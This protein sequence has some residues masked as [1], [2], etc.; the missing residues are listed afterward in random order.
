MKK[1]LVIT[2]NIPNAI[3]RTGT[4]KRLGSFLHALGRL[5]QLDF[6]F[7]TNPRIEFDPVETEHWIKEIWGVNA[8]AI[9]GCN[10]EPGN[11]VQR[12][13]FNEYI[14]PIYSFKHIDK[15]SGLTRRRQTQFL[16]ELLK[17]SQPDLIFAHRLR[18][19]YPVL[20]ADGALPPVIF[21]LDDIEH[22]VLFRSIKIPPVWISKW[23]W[24]LHIPALMLFERKAVKLA[25]RTFVCSKEDES[26]LSKIYGSDRV[27]TIPNCIDIPNEVTI[28]GREKIILFLGVYGYPPNADAANFLITQ[29][30]PKIAEKAPSAKL[31]IAGNRPE[32]IPCYAEVNDENI[33]FTGFVDD[34]KALYAKTRVV[35]CPIFA[36]GGT[37][38]KIIEA[39]AFGKAIVSTEIGAEGLDLTDGAEIILRNTAAELA[40]AC[41]DL[42]ENDQEATKLGNNARAKITDTLDTAQVVKLIDNYVSDIK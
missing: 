19:M 24:Y 39:A 29:V 26:Y 37:R 14:K 27:H 22:K 10:I 35:C 9:F 42:L 7:F 2:E 41:V 15:L 28:P 36:A 34:L 30:W 40:D 21:D 20:G 17:T 11:P 38:I 16:S 8:H 1:I 5:Y 3:N 12:T 4:Y 23:L 6:L 18:T 25:K 13:F 31:V 33:V 32:L